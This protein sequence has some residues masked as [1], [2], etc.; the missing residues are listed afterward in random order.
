[1]T[2]TVGEI[3][4]SAA[5]TQKDRESEYGDNYRTFKA[6]IQA[7]FPQGLD[8]DVAF[9]N[10]FGV[11]MMIVVKMSRLAA[12]DLTHIDSAHDIIVYAAILEKLISER[13]RA[14]S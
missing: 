4:L 3:L 2:K 10:E 5:E 11:F 1:M 7:L 12:S 6:L 9:T 14:G 8:D 13:E